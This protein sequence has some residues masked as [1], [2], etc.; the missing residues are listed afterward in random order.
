MSQDYDYP[1]IPCEEVLE[2]GAMADAWRFKR[3]FAKAADYDIIFEKRLANMLFDYE[4]QPNKVQ[5][6]NVRSPRNYFD[7]GNVD[8]CRRYGVF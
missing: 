6:F 7:G 8:D 1:I 2:S 4:N 5:L 3:Q